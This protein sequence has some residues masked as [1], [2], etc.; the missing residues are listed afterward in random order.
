MDNKTIP[1]YES[2]EKASARIKELLENGRKEQAL[3]LLS[4]A[5]GETI[6]WQARRMVVVHED[7]QDVLQ[8][9]FIR[10]VKSIDSFKWESKLSSWIYRI[11]TNESLRLIDSRNRKLQTQSLDD[12]TKT[13]STSGF[14]DLGDKAAIKLQAA[15]Q[16]LPNKQQATFNLRYYD[17]LPYEEIAAIMDSNIAAVKM[18]YHHAKERIL[19]ILKEN[20]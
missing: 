3:K 15:I 5:F 13:I 19:Q 16:K 2:P 7:A 18:N 4:K 6:Y 14:V 8:E 11:V 12:I 10:I 17:D 9:S 1:T 20:D